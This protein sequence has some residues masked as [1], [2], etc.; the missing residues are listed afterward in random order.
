MYRSRGAGFWGWL[1]SCLS[2]VTL[3]G[4]GG[5]IESLRPSSN[6]G[7]DSSAL[8]SELSAPVREVVRR[9][10]EDRRIPGAA[11]AIVGPGEAN[12]WGLADAIA[13]VVLPEFAL[14]V[15]DLPL[16]EERL[17]DYTGHWRFGYGDARFFARD[18][19]LWIDD[20]GGTGEMLFQRRFAPRRSLTKETT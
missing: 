14:Q 4:C 9:H 2:L 19:H 13:S 11:I 8:A 18:G 20:R 5:E 3:L 6:D 15:V 16:D 1:V 12:P 10:M 7:G 17:A